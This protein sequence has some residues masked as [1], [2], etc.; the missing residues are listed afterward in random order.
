[1]STFYYLACN[2]CKKKTE[3]IGRWVNRVGWLADN[4]N[5][6]VDFIDVH[7]NCIDTVQIVSQHDDESDYQDEFPTEDEAGASTK[8]KI[9]SRHSPMAL[10]YLT[11]KTQLMMLQLDRK[12]FREFA[13]EYLGCG[14]NW[15]DFLGHP[16]S[17]AYLVFEFYPNGNMPRYVS[18]PYF[19]PCTKVKT[20]RDDDGNLFEV[21]ADPVTT[22]AKLETRL[23]PV[24][25]AIKA[26]RSLYIR[27]KEAKQ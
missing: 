18:L 10:R 4:P 2:N 9:E 5:Q 11:N 3:F 26:I 1:M 14:L 13:G 19:M 20:I 24:D 25:L 17:V 15:P 12:L 27:Q 6:I 8:P 21:D 23:D 7:M 22:A 16:A